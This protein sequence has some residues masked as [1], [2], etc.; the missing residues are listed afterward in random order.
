VPN[1][2]V[3]KLGVDP[4]DDDVSFDVFATL[5][6]GAVSAPAVDVAA[7]VVV[8]TATGV[9]G[10]SCFGGAAAGSAVCVGAGSREAVFSGVA[11]EGAQPTT[12]ATSKVERIGT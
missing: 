4:S 9:A 2:D 5:T 7:V 6:L 1:D 3:W 12:R 11:R 10:A 8:A